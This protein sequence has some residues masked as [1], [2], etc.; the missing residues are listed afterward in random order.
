MRY[1]LFIEKQPEDESI[2]EMNL[3]GLFAPFI[4]IIYKD[5]NRLSLWTQVW[6]EKCHI[7][8]LKQINEFNMN[9]LEW[10]EELKVGEKFRKLDS[11]MLDVFS[12]GPNAEK[13]ENE[14]LEPQRKLMQIIGERLKF[15]KSY[16]RGPDAESDFK[17]G[18]YMDLDTK[19]EIATAVTSPFTVGRLQFVITEAEPYKPYE[20]ILLPF[21][22]LTW[23]LLVVTFGIAFGVIFAVSLM[24]K[25]WSNVVYGEGV[26]RPAYNVL[27]TFFGIAQPRL[28][29][30]FF[31]RSLL[32]QF[33]WFSL[34]FRTAYQGVFFELFTTDMRKPQPRTLNELIERNYT[35]K[36]DIATFAIIAHQHKINPFSKYT[37]PI[38]EDYYEIQDH[39]VA[40][41]N[42]QNYRTIYGKFEFIEANNTLINICDILR[43]PSVKTAYLV[44]LTMIESIKRECN[45]KLEILEEVMYESVVGVSMQLHH[46]LYSYIAN[47]TQRLVEA[48]IVQHWYDFFQFVELRA[49]VDPKDTEPKVLTLKMLSFG[50]V[51]CLA[52]SGVAVAVLFVEIICVVSLARRRSRDRSRFRFTR[53]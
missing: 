6:S 15:S 52:T 33:I 1:L 11:C 28:P 37:L 24:R 5:E 36:G 3:E 27:G 53:L 51:I 38:N 46:Y 42:S 39:F 16:V 45:F 21:D 22:E 18:I 41:V 23:Y 35:I 49:R 13:E 9:A 29:R 50:F 10:K 34:I 8:T 31:A 17:I 44:D 20:K 14:M 30:T 12:F 32:I 19:M 43:D 40:A 47:V 4:D 48:G 25:R 7:T 2:N 26:R